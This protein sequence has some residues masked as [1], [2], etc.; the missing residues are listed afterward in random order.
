MKRVWGCSRACLFLL[1]T[2]YPRFW[3]SQSLLVI[4]VGAMLSL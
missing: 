1:G 4:L 3:E 2:S